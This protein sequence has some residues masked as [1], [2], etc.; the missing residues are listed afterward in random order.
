MYMIFVVIHDPEML[1]P[2]LSAWQ[3]ADLRGATII[4]STGMIRRQSKHLPMRY[5]FD[6]NQFYGEGNC[7]VFTVVKDESRIED[8]LAVTESVLGDLDEP[9][10][11]V[12]MA[13]PLTHTKGFSKKPQKK[14]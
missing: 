11:G 10:T 4:E 1:D 12:F 5:F 6:N 9:S 3:E 2:L 14:A 13:F 8:C 7:T